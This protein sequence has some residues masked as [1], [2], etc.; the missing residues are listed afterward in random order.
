MRAFTETE[1][2]SETRADVVAA[3]VDEHDVLGDFLFVGAEVGFEGA[4]FGFVGGALAGA[5]DGA[6]LDGGA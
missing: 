3:E 1:P 6:V 2:N 4:V 5:G